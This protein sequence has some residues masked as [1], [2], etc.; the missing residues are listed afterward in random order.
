MSIGEHAIKAPPAPELMLTALDVQKG[1]PV[2]PLDRLMIMSADEW[3]IFTLELVFYFDKH[4]EQVTRCAGAGDKGR[5][6]IARFDDTLPTQ[7]DESLPYPFPGYPLVDQGLCQFGG[8]S[9][10]LVAQKVGDDADRKL[11]LFRAVFPKSGKEL[12]HAVIDTAPQH[13]QKVQQATQSAIVIRNHFLHDRMW[14][15]GQGGSNARGAWTACQK[16]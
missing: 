14:L 6:V 1:E 10:P 12:G 9:F 4:Y 7:Q 15:S 8:G 5:D 11:E 13:M 3:E 2:H 16:G